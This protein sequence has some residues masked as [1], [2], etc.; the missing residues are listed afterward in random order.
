VFTGAWLH[1]D[2]LKVARS[3][4]RLQVFEYCIMKLGVKVLAVLV[5][6]LAFLLAI[7]IALSPT[8]ARSRATVVLVGVTNNPSGQQVVLLQFT[9]AGSVGV[10]GIPHSV[11]YRVADTWVTEQPVPG[12]ITAD[13][14]SSA[15]LG[16][17]EARMVSVRF[18]TNTTWRLRI[19]FHEQPRGMEGVL[20]RISDL[21]QS[22]GNRAKHTAYTGRNYLAET[23]DIS[24]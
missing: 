15:D 20:A 18:P 13:I 17:H 11:D 5:L 1:T 16:P 12:V 14:A 6:L 2:L 24:P 21:L 8:S 9:N 19:R 10:V 3:E 22:L 7:R 4:S 23:P